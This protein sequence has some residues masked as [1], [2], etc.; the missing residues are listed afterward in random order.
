MSLI[1]TPT[2]GSLTRTSGRPP[3]LAGRARSRG[4]G[5]AGCSFL[6]TL[7][8]REGAQSSPAQSGLRVEGRGRR[9]PSI[10]RRAARR[11]PTA[12]HSVRAPGR[13]ATRRPPPPGLPRSLQTRAPSAADGKRQVTRGRSGSRRRASAAGRRGAPPARALRA[14]GCEAQIRGG[15]FA[16]ALRHLLFRPGGELWFGGFPR[17]R[18]ALLGA[19]CPPTVASLSALTHLAL[20][21]PGRVSFL[22]STPRLPGRDELPTFS[23]LSSLLENTPEGGALGQAKPF[24]STS[25]TPGFNNS[26]GRNTARGLKDPP[27]NSVHREE[28]GCTWIVHEQMHSLLQG[29]VKTSCT[30]LLYLQMGSFVSGSSDV[31]NGMLTAAK[32]TCINIEDKKI[33]QLCTMYSFLPGFKGTKGILKNN[34]HRFLY[35]HRLNPCAHVF[36]LFC[37]FT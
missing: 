32:N 34:C 3:T 11:P 20:A 1:K 24:R 6:R 35:S 2:L 37:V 31:G 23:L 29:F 36:V 25:H 8:A 5:W 19:R 30:F 16:A 17:A 10:T 18:T 33:E 4:S 12:A 22:T 7:R 21:Q 26:L 13:R 27:R 28:E 15:G 14:P 9:E